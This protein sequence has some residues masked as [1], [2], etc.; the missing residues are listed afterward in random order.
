MPDVV[1]EYLNQNVATIPILLFL[2]GML[3]GIML[4]WLVMRR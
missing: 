4:T 3:A 1:M 2:L